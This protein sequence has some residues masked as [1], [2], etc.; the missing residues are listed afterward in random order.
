MSTPGPENP[1]EDLKAI[2][3]GKGYDDVFV[4]APVAPVIEQ[5]SRILGDNGCLNF[6]AGPSRPDFFASINFYDVHYAGHHLVGT[7][8]GNTEDMRISLD[9]MAKGE[10]NPTVF[11]THVGGI[12]SA[13]QTTLDLP[14]IPG[15]KKL[16]YTHKS[17]PMTAIDDFRSWGKA[18]LSSGGWRRSPKRIIVCGRW[19]PNVIC[20]KRRRM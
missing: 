8:G 5:G 11:I 20:W 10:L 15:G 2:N 14:K 16:V 18:I 19:K 6:F 13:A 9:M 4:F 1:V 7:S 12:D 17:M 3:G